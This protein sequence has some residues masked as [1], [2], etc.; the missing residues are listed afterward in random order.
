MNLDEFKSLLKMSLTEL[1]LFRFNFKD[2]FCTH[3]AESLIYYLEGN[4]SLLENNLAKIEQLNIDPFEKDL[5]CQ[6]V[7]IRFQIRSKTLSAEA[8]NKLRALIYDQTLDDSLI[9]EIHFILGLAFEDLGNN[10]LSSEHYNHSYQKFHALGINQKSIKAL[11]NFI[12]SQSRIPEYMNRNY[13]S[14]YKQ[15]Y[16]LSLKQKDFLTAGTCLTNIGIEE[17][18]LQLYNQAK[19]QFARALKILEKNITTHQYYLALFKYLEAVNNL[20]QIHNFKHLLPLVKSNPFSDLNEIA[21]RTLCFFDSHKED[22]K[23]SLSLHEEML[24]KLLLDGPKEKGQL[25][26]S[27]YG[28]TLDFFTKENRFKNLLTRVKKKK[29][30]TFR[31]QDGKYT[32]AS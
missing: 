25:L 1:N 24:V 8:V 17:M 22:A 10:Y 3:Y 27:L 19:H 26:D 16:L 4:L 31:F 18:N 20:N 9:G 5:L 2:T 28:E 12:A 32:I 14:E 7:S 6:L 30:Y 13:I 29:I 21:E 11:H 15:L 23:N